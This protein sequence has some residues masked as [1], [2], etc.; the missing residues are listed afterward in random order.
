[1]VAFNWPRKISLPSLQNNDRATPVCSCCFHVEFA[2]DSLRHREW[3]CC[4][5]ADIQRRYSWNPGNTAQR[6]Q[7][8]CQ[9]WRHQYQQWRQ[10]NQEGKQYTQINNSTT[11]NTHTN[12]NT[13]MANTNPN[14]NSTTATNNR[15]WTFWNRN[16]PGSRSG[17]CTE[18]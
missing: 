8:Q 6:H 2:P 13:K 18:P 5:L 14:A 15:T 10:Q 11:S 16:S 9:P 7:H 3:H 12:A 17:N 4:F 1:M